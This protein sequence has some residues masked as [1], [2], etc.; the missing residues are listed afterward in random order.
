M[1]LIV[2]NVFIVLFLA[3]CPKSEAPG[4]S[5]SGQPPSEQPTGQSKPQFKN[6]AEV[7]MENLHCRKDQNVVAGKCFDIAAYKEFETI[8]AK[9]PTPKCSDLYEKRREISRGA[10]ATVYLIAN[11]M[12]KVPGKT[13]RACWESSCS[14]TVVKETFG[15]STLND[16]KFSKLAS[17][18]GVAPAV[19]AHGKCLENGK[20]IDFKIE[21]Q[22]QHA[23]I[24]LIESDLHNFMADLRG[25]TD[26]LH[27][28]GLVHGDIHTGN[29]GFRMNHG[30]RHYVL[31]DFDKAMDLSLLSNPIAQGHINYENMVVNDLIGGR[32]YPIGGW[33][34]H[35]G[36]QKNDRN[37]LPWHTYI[38]KWKKADTNLDGELDASETKRLSDYMGSWELA[39]TAQFLYNKRIQK[40]DKRVVQGFLADANLNG[41]IDPEELKKM[42]VLPEYI[43]AYETYAADLKA[44]NHVLAKDGNKTRSIFMTGLVPDNILIISGGDRN[45]RRRFP[46]LT[47]RNILE[48]VHNWGYRFQTFSGNLADGC[49]GYWHKIFMILDQME[50]PENKVI[51]WFDDDGVVSKTS[52]MIEQYLDAYPNKGMV[53]A[54]DPEAF[55]YVNTGAIIIR[56]SIKMRELMVEMLKVGEEKRKVGHGWE[57]DNGKL[58]TL[59]ECAQ[60]HLCLHEQQALAELLKKER[61]VGPGWHETVF[62]STTQDWAQV[63]Q[64]V[65]QI[66]LL[67]QRNMNL[68]Y[69]NDFNFKLMGRDNIH[70]NQKVEYRFQQAPFFV[71]CAGPGDKNTCVENLIRAE[72]RDRWWL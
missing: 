60:Q 55:A 58:Q 13:N 27:E 63:V 26:K 24:G 28:Y 22:V 10:T 39:S 54:V 14:E 43:Q 44:K 36:E 56:N 19:Y 8:L 65:P 12:P 57:Y 72:R 31:M 59:Q 69:K 30:K 20:L 41:I 67:T 4:Q 53:I 15:H 51:V 5:S 34:A 2:R 37:Y 71:Q 3:G 62:R 25:L 6:L 7:K 70:S 61:T 40:M 64:V 52:N 11:K 46:L 35:I 32:Y 42:P 21:E 38:Y 66:D 48:F 50:H 9:Q 1:F 29:I 47:E 16:Y 18:L 33:P 68:F 45:E 17:E 23:T 49:V